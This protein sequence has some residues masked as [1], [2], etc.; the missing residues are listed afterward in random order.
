MLHGHVL[1][2]HHHVLDQHCTRTTM[3]TNND[4]GFELCHRRELGSP[5]KKPKLTYHQLK[6]FIRAK[7]RCIDTFLFE[8]KEQMAN[9]GA[10]QTHH[11]AHCA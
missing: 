10:Q 9:A 1:E 2:Q 8:D 4:D 6:K 3:L 7:H 11:L 5:S